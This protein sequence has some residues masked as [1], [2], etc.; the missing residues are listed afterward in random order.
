MPPTAASV[1]H[2]QRNKLYNDSRKL[3]KKEWYLAHKTVVAEQRKRYYCANR[4]ACKRR[5]KS[6]QDRIKSGGAAA[7]AAEAPGHSREEKYPTC[8]A[9]A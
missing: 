4:D 2:K 7:A 8:N 1:A 6:Y 5:V 3:K 9:Y